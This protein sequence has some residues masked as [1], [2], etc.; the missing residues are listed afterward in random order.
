MNYSLFQLRVM[1]DDRT[2]ADY[3]IEDGTF[4]H[5]TLDLRGLMFLSAL[6]LVSAC[7]AQL[8]RFF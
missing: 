3:N 2:L 1:Q 6:C 4:I 7:C 8:V 5:L